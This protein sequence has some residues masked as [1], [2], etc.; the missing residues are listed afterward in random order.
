MVRDSRR[1]GAEESLPGRERGVEN[2]AKDLIDSVIKVAK[3]VNE[4]RRT[5]SESEK[6]KQEKKRMD[7]LR[8]GSIDVEYRI[9]E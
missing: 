8:K 9:K 7:E 5:I 3:A 4:L 6:E 1:H 2:L